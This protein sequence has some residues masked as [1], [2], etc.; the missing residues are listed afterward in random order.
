VTLPGAEIETVNARDLR[1]FLEVGKD[2]STGSRIRS[3][4]IT[5]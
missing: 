3:S 4:S 5:S 2:F 1:A